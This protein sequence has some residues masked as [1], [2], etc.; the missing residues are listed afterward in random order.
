MNNEYKPMFRMLNIYSSAR[1]VFRVLTGPHVFFIWEKDKG[2]KGYDDLI[3][4]FPLT[5]LH[6]IE[7]KTLKYF[8]EG[9]TIDVFFP[10]YFIFTIGDI[11]NGHS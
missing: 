3:N 6:C 10:N 8:K 5:T 1:N 11:K 2:E 7:L 9:A 4:K